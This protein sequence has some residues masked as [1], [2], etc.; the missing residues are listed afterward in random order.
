MYVL[1]LKGVNYENQYNTDALQQQ[2][3]TQTVDEVAG[4]LNINPSQY[5]LLACI[6]SLLLGINASRLGT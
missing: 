5:A 2:F 4:A 6:R 1:H 3:A